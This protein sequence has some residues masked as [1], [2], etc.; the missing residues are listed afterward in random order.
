VSETEHMFV[1]NSFAEGNSE[2]LL[3]F[4]HVCIQVAARRR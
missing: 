3:S 4:I 1:I 2:Y